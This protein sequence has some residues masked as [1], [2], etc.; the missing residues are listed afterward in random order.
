[1]TL[2]ELSPVREKL[3]ALESS[4]ELVWSGKVVSIPSTP[5]RDI[6]VLAPQFHP[7]KKGLSYKEGQGRLLHDLASIELQALELAFR[8][9]AEYPEAPKPFRE[10]LTALVRSEASHLQ[11]CLDGLESLGFEWGHWPAHL[12]LW[13]GVDSR[14]S[15]LDRI[16][17]VHRYLEGSGLDAGNQLL[18]RLNGVSSGN[19][20]SIL[21]VINTEEIDHVL[22]GSNW[23]RRIC[24][25]EGLDPNVDFPE[26]IRKL[27]NILPK[28][29]EK[30]NPDMRKRAGFNDLEI[31]T[32][33]K[34]RQSFL[35]TP[36]M[37]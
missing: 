21:K 8:S 30:I 36:Q 9:L 11:L 4:L 31:E 34:L 33:E 16:L 1:M 20:E 23:Y 15:L 10:E 32:L 2:L 25:Q 28:R 7:P 3:K 13:Q 12:A 5:G 27:R 24:L 29:I 37:S 17:I 14:D 35:S 26:R 18:R 19:T 6:T 22:F